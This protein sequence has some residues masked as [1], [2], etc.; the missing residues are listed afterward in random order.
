MECEVCV[1]VILFEHVSEFKYLGCVL[2]ES[3]TEEGKHR[4]KV[5]SERRVAG[6][7]RSLVNAWSVDER[8]DEGVLRRF[9]HV[10]TNTSDR[11]VRPRKRLIDIANNCLQKRDLNVRQGE[12]CMK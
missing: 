7:F 8:I 3:G 12:W 4:R 5:A 6:T 10:E 1:D 2:D 11:S 9:G